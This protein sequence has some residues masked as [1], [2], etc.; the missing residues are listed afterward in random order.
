[1][2]MI[3]TNQKSRQNKKHENNHYLDDDKNLQNDVYL[4]FSS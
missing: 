1:M 3:E 2:T 4:C